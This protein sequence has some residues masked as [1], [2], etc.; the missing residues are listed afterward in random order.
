MSE[1]LACQGPLERRV[2]P[3][4]DRQLTRTQ[5]H[6]MLD[7]AQRCENEGW[8]R[9]NPAQFWKRHDSIKAWLNAQIDAVA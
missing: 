2:R 7:Y 8:Y 6:Q 5:L 3:L 1:E 4:H 9:G